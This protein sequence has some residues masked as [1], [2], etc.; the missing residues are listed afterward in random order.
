M[1][2][3]FP[4]VC[5]FCWIFLGGGPSSS[6]SFVTHHRASVPASLLCECMTSFYFTAWR[7]AFYVFRIECKGCKPLL[8]E[9]RKSSSIC[10]LLC[11]H[12]GSR[13]VLSCVLLLSIH[14]CCGGSRGRFA[15]WA[16]MGSAGVG[17]LDVSIQSRAPFYSPF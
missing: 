1:A 3:G 13:T 14:P 12:A 11:T 4:S 10:G 9:R 2:A 6:T 16:P 17:P 7:K 5:T 15:G 8:A